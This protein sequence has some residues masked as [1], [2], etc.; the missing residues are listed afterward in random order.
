MLYTLAMNDVHLSSKLKIAKDILVR[1]LEGEAVLL[2]IQTGVYFGLDK[3]AT[4]TWQ[5]MQKQ[6][7]LQGVLDSLLKDYEIDKKTCQDDLLKFASNLQKNAIVEI[8]ED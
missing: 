3:T 4:A 6:K 7:D 8:Y 1:E 5:L 2:N